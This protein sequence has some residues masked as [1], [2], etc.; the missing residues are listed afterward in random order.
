MSQFP[1]K[2]KYL[3]SAPLQNKHQLPQ[4]SAI[5]FVVVNQKVL[6]IG[7]AKN[8]RERWKEHHRW[9]Q[10]Q[11]FLLVDIPVDIYWEECEESSLK[12]LENQY[13]GECNPNL[14][15]TPTVRVSDRIN[16]DEGRVN[17]WEIWR[18]KA[19][20]LSKKQRKIQAPFMWFHNLKNYD[21]ICKLLRILQDF[22]PKTA[23]KLLEEVDKLDEA[24]K[25]FLNGELNLRKYQMQAF[26]LSYN[27]TRE[28]Q[29]AGLVS[30]FMPR[31]I[32]VHQEIAKIYAETLG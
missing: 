25:K 23:E 19:R 13:I 10:L 7:E 28:L 20:N 1:E 18:R 21:E 16:Q 29:S 15:E 11:P 27:I 31:K 12:K 8:L 6:Y 30:S 5:Y 32:Y 2:F 4:I 14:N 22:E 17:I 3:P 26:Y 24:A 9:S